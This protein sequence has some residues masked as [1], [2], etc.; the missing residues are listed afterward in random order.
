MPSSS[1]LVSNSTR[2]VHLCKPSS[3]VKRKQG[4]GKNLV[5]RYFSEALSMLQSGKSIQWM[6]GGGTRK[7]SGRYVRTFCFVNKILKYHFNCSNDH[8]VLFLLFSVLVIDVVSSRSFTWGGLVSRWSICQY[9]L[10]G[11]LYEWSTLPFRRNLSCVYQKIFGLSYN[12]Q[13]AARIRVEGVVIWSNDNFVMYDY[14]ARFVSNFVDFLGMEKLQFWWNG[15][16]NGILQCY[17]YLNNPVKTS[18]SFCTKRL[19]IKIEKI[20]EFRI[21]TYVLH[22][23]EIWLLIIVAKI[24]FYCFRSVWLPLVLD[25]TN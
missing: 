22:I 9:D 16:H 10:F 25:D 23:K 20:L 12:V 14:N 6:W 13:W 3:N 8:I 4:C 11:V 7:V 17:N 24:M 5:E 2:R 1:Y 15:C 19:L 18:S 21:V